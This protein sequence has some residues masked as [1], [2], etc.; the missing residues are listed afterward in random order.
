MNETPK[1]LAELQ[2]EVLA[3][4]K[5]AAQLQKENLK[6]KEDIDLLKRQMS[7]QGSNRA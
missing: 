2:E 7:Q 4:K 1:S 3:L 6:T 5:L